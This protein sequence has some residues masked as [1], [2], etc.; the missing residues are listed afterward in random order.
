[1]FRLKFLSQ[2]L[3]AGF[4]RK[5]SKAM[6]EYFQYCGTFSEISMAIPQEKPGS[7][8]E[9]LSWAMHLRAFCR[10]LIY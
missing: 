7:R 8:P 9:L 1:M 4:F 3:L 6:A 2:D 5:G 10:S